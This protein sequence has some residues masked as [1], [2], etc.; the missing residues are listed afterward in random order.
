MI[1]ISI[2]EFSTVE[3]TVARSPTSVTD[4]TKNAVKHSQLHTVS[5]RILK[6]TIRRLNIMTTRRPSRRS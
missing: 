5:N 2:N 6:L 4:Q 1:G 3:L